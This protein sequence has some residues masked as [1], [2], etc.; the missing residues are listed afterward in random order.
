MTDLLIDH[1]RHEL[2][3]RLELGAGLAELQDQVIESA[4]GPSEDER[5]ALW[6]Y[7]WA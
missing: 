2:S 7:A 5:A 6:L 4:P 1:V 3:V